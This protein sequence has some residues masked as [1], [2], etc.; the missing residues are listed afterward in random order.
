MTH[1]DLPPR[2]PGALQQGLAPWDVALADSPGGLMV[3]LVENRV[4]HTQADPRA[5]CG[6]GVSGRTRTPFELNGC[7]RCCKKALKANLD[8]VVD[9]TGDVITI[10]SVLDRPW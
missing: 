6:V 5:L 7:K 9:V 1:D 10:Q 2:P 4:L 8:A 3:H